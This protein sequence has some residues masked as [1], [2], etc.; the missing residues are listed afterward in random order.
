MKNK[1]KR[2]KR[3]IAMLACLLLL[4]GTAGVLTGFSL[5]TEEQKLIDEGYE[6]QETEEDIAEDYLKWLLENASKI[7]DRKGEAGTAIIP[8][9]DGETEG[10]PAS[11]DW[12]DD[13][14]FL[15]GG[16]LW[17][18][19][20]AQGYLS[21]VLE[22]PKIQVRRGVYC[23]PTYRQIDADFD[24]WMTVL[25]NPEMR[26]GKT[27]LFVIGHNSTMCGMSFNKMVDAR[28]G[29]IFYLYNYTGVY[30][31]KVTDIFAEGRTAAVQKYASDL[32]LP[33]TYCYIATCGRD[34]MPDLNGNS[35]RYRDFIVKGELV[36][37]ISLTEY[38]KL[39]LDDEN[40]W[41][42]NLDEQLK[43]MEARRKEKEQ[44]E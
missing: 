22:Y 38:G 1:K 25:Y 24:R 42:S 41:K 7:E 31:Y 20:Y 33:N 19:N 12:Y 32:T 30:T 26:L 11:L 6:K 13:V 5:I 4:A 17:T 35:T 18:P 14:Y 27:P 10:T 21:F 34:Y 23:A 9:G 2:T 40:K 15:N 37:H 8:N 16:V 29:D 36:E 43:T 28:L 44:G 39:V 3:V